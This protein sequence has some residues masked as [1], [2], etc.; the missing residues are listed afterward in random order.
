M[1]VTKT[2]SQPTNKN[3]LN[4]NDRSQGIQLG[5]SVDHKRKITYPNKF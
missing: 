2:V 5:K 4:L 3:Q 1:E